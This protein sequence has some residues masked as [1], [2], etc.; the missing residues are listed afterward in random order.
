MLEG[1][2]KYVVI[3]DLEIDTPS[4]ILGWTKQKFWI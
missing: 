3:R 1:F 2:R 4:Q